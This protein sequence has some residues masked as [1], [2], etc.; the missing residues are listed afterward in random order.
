MLLFELFRLFLNLGLRIGCKSS[1]QRSTL[2]DRNSLLNTYYHG[3]D[4]KGIVDLRLIQLYVVV[5][6]I[7]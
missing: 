5:S 2:G 7:F 3:L 4:T 1:G 6:V